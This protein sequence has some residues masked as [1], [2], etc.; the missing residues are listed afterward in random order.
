MSQAERSQSIW[1]Q[2]WGLSS[3][4]VRA[5]SR[6]LIATALAVLACVLY[7][8]ALNE[9]R[10]TPPLQLAQQA[11]GPS[12]SAS[13]LPVAVNWVE[14]QGRFIATAAQVLL[15]LVLGDRLGLVQLV[16][17]GVATTVVTHGLKRAVDDVHWLG[18]HRAGERPNG[19]DHNMPS[20]HSS[21]AGSALG[22]LWRRFGAWHL[23]Y[24]LPLLLATMSTRV[25][26]SAHTLSAVLAGAL[27]GVVV[28]YVMTTPRQRPAS[29]AAKAR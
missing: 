25:F 10:Q 26:L 1:R 7:P 15:P 12:A 2:A 9:Y 14:D 21:M 27:I 29:V 20:G 18:L 5:H 22:Y 8:S 13:A 23:L 11:L 4:S 19:G 28:S 6:L 16:Y 3:A 17:A 24:L